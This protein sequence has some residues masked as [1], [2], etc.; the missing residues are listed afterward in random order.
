VYISVPKKFRVKSF[1]TVE[2]L[3]WAPEHKRDFTVAC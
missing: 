2:A 1:L 3:L